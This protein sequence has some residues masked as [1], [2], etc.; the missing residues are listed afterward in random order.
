MSRT[1][2]WLGYIL[3]CC[4]GFVQ[5]ALIS[6]LSLIGSDV[7]KLTAIKLTIAISIF[8]AAGFVSNIVVGWTADKFQ[9]KLIFLSIFSFLS[10]LGLFGLLFPISN[11]I[12]ITLL[13]L[14]I[15]P[16]S[17]VVSLFFGYLYAMKIGD[18]RLI[19]NRA[20]YSAAWVVGP[21][22]ASWFVDRFGYNALFGCMA[23]VATLTGFLP[24]FLSEPKQLILNE[25]EENYF[26]LKNI[27]VVI[28]RTTVVILLQ[29]AIAISTICLPIVI[30]NEMGAAASYVGLAFSF[31]AATEVAIMMLLSRIILVVANKKS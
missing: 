15:A 6:H 4:L 1:E 31:L 19:Y 24:W 30:K 9:K 20:L 29:S 25:S 11:A 3:L 12:R 21:A 7:I 5:S 2:Q 18:S 14:L 10:A 16:S 26:N 23:T 8:Y 13:I 27:N 17:V 28:H 22:I